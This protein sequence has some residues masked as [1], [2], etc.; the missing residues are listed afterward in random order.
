M[1]S[2]ELKQAMELAGFREKY[3]IENG[4]A[5]VKY[6]NGHKLIIFNYSDSNEY[7]DAN[8]ATYDATKK[9]WIN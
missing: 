5:T 2:R 8:G 9:A 6:M 3:A 4:K 7:Q 1:N